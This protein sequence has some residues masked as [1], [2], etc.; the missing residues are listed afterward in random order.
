[1]RPLQTRLM[2]RIAAMKEPVYTR[3]EFSE[4][5]EQRTENARW[6]RQAKRK[7]LINK[8]GQPTRW[9]WRGNMGPYVKADHR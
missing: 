6:E 8:W 9:I 4:T 5:K 7:G 1:M 3:Y 2:A